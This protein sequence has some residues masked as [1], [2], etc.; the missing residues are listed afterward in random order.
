MKQNRGS[1][2]TQRFIEKLKILKEQG[3]DVT[4]ITQKD[5]IETL[6]KKSGVVISEEQAEKLGI[7]LIDRIGN[8]KMNIT[9]TY[10]GNGSYEMPTKEQ[11]QKLSEL[12]VSLELLEKRN[13]VQ[14]FIEKLEIL[15][16]QGIDVTK[17]TRTDTIQTLAEKSGVVLTEKKAK[18]LGI[19]LIDRIGNAKMNITNAYR[20]NGCYK[21]LTK[22]EVQ[23]LQN[24]GINLEK[25]DITQE[26][27]EKLKILEKQG[28]DVSNIQTT[29][30]IQT[31]AEKSGVVITEEK[32]EELGIKLSD[33][34]GITKT[35]IARA[36]RGKGACKKPSQEQVQELLEL[37]ISLEARD[38]IQEFIEKLEILKEQGIDVT[39]IIQKDTIETLAEKSGVV[40]T[41]EKAEELGIELS[42]KI[43]IT[44]TYITS[45]HRGKGYGKKP[46]QDQVQSLLELGISLGLLRK[47]DMIQ[48]FIKKIEILKE[49]GIDVTKI[50]QKDTIETLAEKS[51]VIITEEKVKELGIELS[52]KIGQTKKNIISAY[53]GNEQYKKPTK[54]EVQK[55]QNLGINLE[56]RD[57]TQEFIEK[58]EILTKLG[59]NV[60]KINSRDT[61]RTLA[62]KSGIVLTEEQAKKLG[63]K[64]SD[65]IGYTKMSIA[66]AYRGKGACKKPSQEQVQELL[67][68]GI[69]LEARDVIQEFI[70]KLEI[71]KEQGIDV[72]KIIQKDTI[73]TLAEKSGVV[74]TEEKAEE[75]G[76]ELSDKIGITKTYIASAHRGK[77]SG[78]KPT[79]EQVQEL[80]N[81]GISLEKRKRTGKEIAEASISSIKNMEVSD[82][83]DRELKEVVKEVENKKSNQK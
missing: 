28:I 1:N 21:K 16:E 43:G 36:Y 22:E 35:Y 5:T 7:E 20:G 62:K 4:K 80:Q 45:A 29:Y 42:D 66:R 10:R 32:A 76:I 71:L 75:L 33:K 59:V 73:E 3:I 65:K 24:L 8:A 79:Q 19:E 38:V 26:F 27:I 82:K 34:I 30:T 56:A 2:G 67:E 13:I 15:K 57:T 40:L 47:K 68:L 58:L 77:G 25:R 54:E 48:E 61:I 53:R 81:L 51:G 60:A 63:I 39:K 12:G 46:S 74:L 11:V 83:A 37:G 64:L 6:A 14:E 18:E 69:S 70:E 55:L 31:L 41:E 17:I 49:Q 44:K 72:T 52:D 23:K 9:N 50:A 78:K